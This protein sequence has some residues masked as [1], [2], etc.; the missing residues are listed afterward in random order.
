MIMQYNTLLY[1]RVLNT[2]ILQSSLA[3]KKHNKIR[4]QTKVHYTLKGERMRLH[5]ILSI[6]SLLIFIFIIPKTYKKIQSV[7]THQHV[8]IFDLMN[9][10]IKENSAGFAKQIGYGKIASY[11]LTHW[12]HPGYRC[13]DMLDA[14]SNCEAQKP[15]I[16]VTLK[17]KTMPRSL[18]ELQ[19][20]KK[21]ASQTKDEILQAITMLDAQK[22]FSSMKEKELMINIMNIILDPNATASMIEPIKSTINLAQK[23]KS[24]GYSIYIFANAPAELYTAIE[25]KYPD[26]INIFDGVVI[27]SNIKTIKPDV[28]IF[29]HLFATHN[30]QPEYCILIDDLPETVIAAKQLGMQAFVHDK[31]L[32]GKLKKC[33]V[34]F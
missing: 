13:L 14:M 3:Y 12:R 28:A 34:K 10:I 11:T 1:K 6:S 29:D 22:H 32:V 15:H 30:L 2:Q 9:V 18:I 8:I 25:K 21:T 23:L 19:E 17:N 5:Y 33:G 26:I 20:G 31:N 27:S 4:L 16:T 7:D 24:A